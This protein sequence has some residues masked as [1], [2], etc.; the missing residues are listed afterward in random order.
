MI[1]VGD[2]FGGVAI[3]PVPEPE[4]YALMLGGLGPLGFVGRR[5]ASRRPGSEGG[6]AAARAPFAGGPWA[7]TSPATPPRR[8]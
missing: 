1:V 2:R 8:P 6:S 3:A 5:R 7:L 4:T